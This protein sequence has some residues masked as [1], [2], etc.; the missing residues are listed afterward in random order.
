MPQQSHH[1]P[2][3]CHTMRHTMQVLV[4]R[5][6]KDGEVAGAALADSR[7]QAFKSHAALLPSSPIQP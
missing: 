4:E 1:V 7:L 6:R 2:A 3:M 5:I